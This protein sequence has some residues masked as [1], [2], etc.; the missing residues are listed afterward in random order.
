[1]AVLQMQ[2]VSICALKKDRKSILEKLQSMG[3][4]EVSQV[5]E[6]ESGFEKQDTQGTRILFEKKASS[7]DQALEIL[8]EYAPEKTSLLS[9][10]EGKALIEKEKYAESI[11]KKED[12]MDVVS[13]LIGW[14]K[15]IAECRANIQKTENQIEALSPWLSLDV[16][17]NFEG[18]GSVKA[19]WKFFKCYDAGRNLY[20]D[21]R[22]CT[23]CRRCR[24]YDSFLRQRQYLCSSTLSERAGRTG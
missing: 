5:L 12:I 13:D 7:A 6:D 9:S 11:S 24:C 18:T 20:T 21:S 4:M 22:T 16:P 14:Q 8:Q 17:M 1:M 15:E 2:R 23:G 19:D 10:L 3:V